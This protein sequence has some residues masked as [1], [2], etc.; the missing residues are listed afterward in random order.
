MSLPVTGNPMAHSP[1]RLIGGQTKLSIVRINTLQ[2]DSLSNSDSRCLVFVDAISERLDEV[3]CSLSV[4]VPLF[5]FVTCRLWPCSGPLAGQMCKR[6]GGVLGGWLI[7]TTSPAVAPDR[8][9]TGRVVQKGL[10]G[11]M[12]AVVVRSHERRC[13]L[14]R[15]PSR[16]RTIPP[17]MQHN[18]IGQ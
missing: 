3:L 17:S 11:M 16:Y 14:T 2:A 8:A 4:V 18:S 5:G 15:S 7:R 9:A 13:Q 6:W 12:P 10:F 1:R